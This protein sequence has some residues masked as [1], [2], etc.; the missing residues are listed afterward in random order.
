VIPYK[1]FSWRMEALLF[2]GANEE[3]GL[4][5]DNIHTSS[6]ENVRTNMQLKDVS[7]LKDLS[8]Q[9]EKK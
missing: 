4:C 2:L 3:T 7:N 9:Q 8:A 6:F 5:G 1:K